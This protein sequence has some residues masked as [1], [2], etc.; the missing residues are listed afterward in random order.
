MIERKSH[1]DGIVPFIDKP[2]IKV[3]TGI[4]RCGK[5]TLLKQ[6]V[7][8]LEKRNVRPEQI[9]VIN[10]ELMEFDGLKN[11]QD[12]YAYIKEKQ[13]RSAEKSYVFVDEVQEVNEWEKAIN[14]LLAE[15]C[16]DI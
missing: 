12:F 16:S 15:Q 4:R 9:I 1:I 11:Y 14:S 13:A 7:G 2:V 5:S 3:I 10:M 6:I 8:I